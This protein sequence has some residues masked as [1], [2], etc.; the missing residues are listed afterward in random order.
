MSLRKLGKNFTKRDHTVILGGPGNSL[1]RNCHCQIEKDINF[2][3]EKTSDTNVRFIN[4][5]ERHNEPW[6]NEK[7]RS[8]NLRL[9]QALMGRGTS[10]IGVIDT[11]SIVR[12]EYTTQP[13]SKFAR[14]EEV[15]ASHC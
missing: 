12:E 7:V 14:Q 4:L 1:D 6:M 2:I 8:V 13:P 9:D 5:F 3:A 11:A 10:D 15:H